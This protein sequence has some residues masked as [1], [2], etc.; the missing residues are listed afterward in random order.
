MLEKLQVIIFN[1]FL[2]SR[3]QVL[4]F[5]SQLD[6]LMPLVSW[7]WQAARQPPLFQALIVVICPR[8]SFISL[9]KALEC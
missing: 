3:Q 7:I 5:I 9:A 6:Q 4:S 2:D 1:F 8:V